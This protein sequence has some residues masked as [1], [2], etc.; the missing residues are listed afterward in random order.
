MSEPAIVVE[1]LVRR[2]GERAA[3]DGLDLEVATGEVVGLLGH[4]GA[5]KTTTV[6]LLNGLLVPQEG[7][8]RVL[9]L[10]PMEDGEAL[11]ARVGVLTENPALDERMSAKE[12]LSLFAA[13][14]GVPEAERSERADRLLE[15]LG[16]SER[17]NDRVGGYSK[18]MKQRLALARTLLH[19]PELLY[20]DEPTSG[21]DPV[22]AHEVHERIRE[23]S[24]RGRT[25]LLCTHNLVEAQSLCHRVLVL[26]NG[27][28][29]AEGTPRELVGR[30]ETSGGLRIDV[31]PE[32]ADE[33]R[34]ALGELGARVRAAKATDEVVV[35]DVAAADIPALVQRLVEADVRIYAVV[36][37]EPTLED[38]Y[39][40][41]HDASPTR[42]EEAAP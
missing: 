35:D 33:A 5:G 6:R 39:L 41:L 42:D 37:D 24:E 4:N 19:D 14:F 26:Q 21:L 23:L 18:G 29:I 32:Q 36:P 40:S 11:R 22:A 25:L 20:L 10:D 34:A 7:S 30:I 12:T 17:A 1:G 31:A 27:R 28:V 2:F 8:S 15:E 9:G 16:L 38:F 3:V 13:L